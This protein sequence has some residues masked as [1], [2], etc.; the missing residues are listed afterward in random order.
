[1]IDSLSS[2]EWLFYAQSDLDSAALILQGSDNFHIVVYHSHQAVEKILKR[3]LLIKK[4]QYPFN[5][6]LLRLLEIATQFRSTEE[7]IEDLSFLMLIYS[8]TRYPK[9]DRISR[10]EAEKSLNVAKRILS[11]FSNE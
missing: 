4:G 5:H 2:S 9:G 1:M 8:G 10:Q 11:E 6:D 3:Y 7:Y